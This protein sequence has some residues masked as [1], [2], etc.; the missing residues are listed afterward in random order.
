MSKL[1][2]A[3]SCGTMRRRPPTNYTMEET[4]ITQAAKTSSK[5]EEGYNFWDI[6][7][8][9]A[10]IDRCND[11]NEL[12]ENLIEMINERAKVE[13]SY[14]KSLTSWQ[15]KWTEFL[16]K[17]SKEY[18]TTKVACLSMLQTAEKIADYHTSIQISLINKSNSPIS[19]IKYWLKVNYAKEHIHFK[20][21]NEFFEQFKYAQKQWAEYFKELKKTEKDYHNSVKEAVKSE[22]EK[23]KAEKNPNVK[24]EEK[25]K[26]RRSVEKHESEQKKSRSK[27]ENQLKIADSF[28]KNYVD[29]MKR[30]FDRTQDFEKLRMEFFKKIYKQFQ[31]CFTKSSVYDEKAKD[32]IFKDLKEKLDK[33][34]PSKDVEWWSNKFGAGMTPVWPT[35]V[36]YSA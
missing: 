10:V 6:D 11:G 20:K 21:R 12:C 2:R 29:D 24:E 28:K 25:V 35:F 33:L 15:K 7:G 18:G 17:E 3:L 5:K 36:E 8:F 23:N 1:I 19:E 26:F 16:N 14:A 27:Y 30:V 34:E 31:E 4:N 22:Q 32:A 13:E 9:E